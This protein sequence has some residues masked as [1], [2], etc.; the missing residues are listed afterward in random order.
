MCSEI[1]NMVD[2][3]LFEIEC[4]EELGNYKLADVLTQKMIKSASN[5]PNDIK[6][7]ILKIE[8]VDDVLYSHSSK[9]FT[10]YCK[11]STTKSTKNKIREQASPYDVSFIYS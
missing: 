3:Y 7:N 6:K 1:I 10:V 2:L 4:T 11:A 5:K 9:K 8:G